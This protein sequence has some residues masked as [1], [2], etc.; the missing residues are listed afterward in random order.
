M[1]EGPGTAGG[2]FLTV[3]VRTQGCRP[4]ALA[5]AVRSLLAQADPDLEVVVVRHVPDDGDPPAGAVTGL[6]DQ[7]TD[8]PAVHQLEVSGAAR[9][10]PLNA[11]LDVARGAY[12]GFL[13]DDDLALPGMVGVFRRGAES[14]PGMVLRSVTLGQ[15]WSADPA[16]GEPREALGPPEE[17]FTREFDLLEHLNHNVTPICSM[18]LPV[19]PVRAAGLRFDEELPVME[20]WHMF[21]RAALRFGVHPVDE[22]TAIYRRLDSGNS[23]ALFDP[24][25]WEQARLL[26][27]ERFGDGPVLLPPGTVKRL[28]EADFQRGGRPLSV[29]DLQQARR[30]LA[31]LAER[32][33]AVE[34]EHAAVLASRSY[35]ALAPVRRV[36]ARLRRQWP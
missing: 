21:V 7:L 5:E 1:T 32:L 16:T 14:A 3:A 4:K 11:A 2:P 30:E 22:P 29:T 12:L 18:A 23:S 35:R 8:H 31:A 36:R 34:A 27:V 19:G 33:R 10:R 28:S 20:D 24:A 13:D 15:P 17:Q 9:G 25:A 26:A 6:P